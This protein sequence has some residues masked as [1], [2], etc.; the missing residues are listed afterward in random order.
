VLSLKVKMRRHD[1]GSKELITYN[2]GRHYIT[3]TLL[4]IIIIIFATATATTNATMTATATER[5][6]QLEDKPATVSMDTKHDDGA[7]KNE[8]ETTTTTT[9]TSISSTTSIARS[10]VKKEIGRQVLRQKLAKQRHLV[11]PQAF[12]PEY[13]DSLFPE[14]LRLFAPQTVHY[15][16]GV[17]AVKE[18]KISCY[19]EV[20]DGGIPC[21]DP[22]L[23]LLQLYTPLLEQCNDLFLYWYRQQHACNNKHGGSSSK[24]SSTSRSSVATSPQC[25]R[26][27]TFLTR[28]TPNPG[29]QALLKVRYDVHERIQQ[30]MSQSVSQYSQS[31]QYAT[32]F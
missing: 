6:Q 15:N 8:N 3:R 28:Y 4:E 29:E 10:T 27:M 20:M 1:G 11:V 13:L 26:I 14:T 30:S 18:W 9:T 24:S 23:D 19:L 7:D 25:Q 31:M 16:G 12:H 21:T 17:A 5:T 22:N 32:V 2:E